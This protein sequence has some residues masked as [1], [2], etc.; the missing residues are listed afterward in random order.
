MTTKK[1]YNKQIT[2]LSIII[3]IVIASLFSIKLDIEV[4]VFLPPI[5]ATINAITAVILV[6]AIWAIKN[7]KRK[8]HESLIKIAMSLTLV[9]LVLY[10]I[11]HATSDDTHFGG[12]GTIKYVYF[13]RQLNTGVN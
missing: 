11:Y 2:A 13:F 8:L 5:Y 10:I 4:P 6:T 12:E 9:F 1:N 7:K 3:P